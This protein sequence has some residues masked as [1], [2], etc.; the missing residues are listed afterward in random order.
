MQKN[1]LKENVIFELNVIFQELL[2]RKS[3]YCDHLLTVAVKL[4][5]GDPLSWVNNKNKHVYTK[6]SS[7][8][9]GF[10]PSKIIW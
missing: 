8:D 1:T 4:C 10:V 2:D 6:L 7:G 3:D 9:S 5:P